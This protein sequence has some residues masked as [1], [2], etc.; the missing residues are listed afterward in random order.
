M[1]LSTGNI[2]NGVFAAANSRG[3]GDVAQDIIVYGT[4]AYIAVSFSNTVEVVSVSDNKAK[5]IK[6]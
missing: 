2:T 1:E 4:K 3:L 6:L 5:Q